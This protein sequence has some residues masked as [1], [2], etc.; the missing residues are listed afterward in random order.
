MQEENEDIWN[1]LI[2]D[3]DEI[4]YHMLRGLLQ[5]IHPHLFQIKWLRVASELSEYACDPQYDVVFLEYRF[6]VPN[7]L[8][9]L[10]QMEKKCPGAPVILLVTQ[11]PLEIQEIARE[12]SP[13]IFLEKRALDANLLAE[14]VRTVMSRDPGSA[15]D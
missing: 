1:L 9:F 5:E 3:N 2:I 10:D 8:E 15:S 6:D 14:A 7:G 4:D 12:H 13:Y 11:L